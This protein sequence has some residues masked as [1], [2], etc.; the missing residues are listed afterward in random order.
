MDD[1]FNRQ[2]VRKFILNDF[3]ITNGQFRI[4]KIRS[5]TK[6]QNIQWKYTGSRVDFNLLFDRENKPK[7]RHVEDRGWF[8]S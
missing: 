2:N 3:M 4:K 6:Q 5:M 8:Q 1:F 7:A